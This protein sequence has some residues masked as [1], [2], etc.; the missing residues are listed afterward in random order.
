MDFTLTVNV[1]VERT[2]GKFATKDEL[3]EQIIEA[4]DGA[5]PSTLE[6]ENGGQYEITEWNVDE[7]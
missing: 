3:K 4:I 7:A 2:E 1:S 6:G 5:N